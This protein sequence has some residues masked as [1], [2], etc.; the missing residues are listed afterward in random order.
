MLSSTYRNV[1]AAVPF[2]MRYIRGS[3]FLGPPRRSIR[4]DDQNGSSL[5]G[6]KTS[7]RAKDWQPRYLAICWRVTSS[8]GWRAMYAKALALRA[9]FDPT[10]EAKNSSETG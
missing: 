4:Q 1:W 2:V 7:L 3:F 10:K 9:F 6:S 5:R 8:S